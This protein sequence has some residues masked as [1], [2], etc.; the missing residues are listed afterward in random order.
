MAMTKAQER[1][2]FVLKQEN[3]RLKTELAIERR[4]HPKTNVAVARYGS[5]EELFYLPERSTIRFSIDQHREIDCDFGI[6][7]QYGPKPYLHVSAHN[8]IL[9]LPVASNCFNVD[10]S[11]D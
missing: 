4:N 9:V 7:R 3:E 1:E 2:M 6:R 10:V 11:D 8:S 5:E